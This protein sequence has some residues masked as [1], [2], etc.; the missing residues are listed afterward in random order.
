[1]SL[2]LSVNGV[3]FFPV[4]GASSSKCSEIYAGPSSFS[5]PETQSIRDYLLQFKDSNS[6]RVKAYLS[7]HAFAEQ[8]LYPWGYGADVPAHFDEL[9]NLAEIAVKAMRKTNLYVVGPSGKT[10]CKLIIL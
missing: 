1:M 7:L 10:L 3:N 5:E 6:S 8:W 9:H 2:V 4:S